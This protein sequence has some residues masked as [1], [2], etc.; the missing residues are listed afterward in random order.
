MTAIIQ[1]PQT[2]QDLL[3][4]VFYSSRGYDQTNVNFYQ[5]VALKGKKTVILKE[6]NS[7]YRAAGDMSGFVKPI[8]NS[9]KYEETYQ[10]RL[11]F[12]HGEITTKCKYDYTAWLMED[13]NSEKYTSSY[14]WV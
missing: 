5:V 2:N 12:N 9:F 11:N 7:D 14:A 3:G 1:K 13:T 6:L 4:K 8:L 10:R